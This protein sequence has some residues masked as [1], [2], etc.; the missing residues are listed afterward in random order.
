MLKRTSCTQSII[1][2]IFLYY[3]TIKTSSIISRVRGCHTI[4]DF[5]L[6]YLEVIYVRVYYD[7]YVRIII[8]NII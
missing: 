5:I 4:C 2:Y 1:F 6:I 3:Y 8:L 7:R